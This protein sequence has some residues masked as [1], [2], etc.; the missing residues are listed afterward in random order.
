[1]GGDDDMAGGRQFDDQV[2]Q[3]VEVVQIDVGRRFVEHH[4]GSVAQHR[5]GQCQPGALAG[6]QSDA[7]VAERGLE[8][9]SAFE[10][11]PQSHDT[12]CVGARTIGRLWR[13]EA[14]RVDHRAGHQQRALGRQMGRRCGD[15]ARLGAADIRHQIEQGALATP[16]LPGDDGESGSS[17]AAQTQPIEDPWTVGIPERHRVDDHGRDGSNLGSG[18]IGGEDV[19]AD[20][21]EHRSSVGSA[22]KLL[23]DSADRPVRLGRQQ[24]RGKAD[25]EFDRSV[26]QAKP[27]GDGHHGDRDRGEQLECHRREERRAKRLG[28]CAAVPVS[29][30]GDRLDLVLGP[31][32]GDQRGQAPDDIEEVAG[33]QVHRSPT[34]IALGCG[35]LADEGGEEG[36]QRQRH[37]EDQHTPGVDEEHDHHGEDRYDGCGDEGGEIAGDI[38]LDAAHAGSGQ[39]ERHIVARTPIGRSR[40]PPAQQSQSHFAAHLVACS[41]I[42]D[43]ADGGKHPT[44]HQ[45]APDER[46]RSTEWFGGDE[47]RDHPGDGQRLPERH[48]ARCDA[49]AGES[50]RRS[51]GSRQRA[52]QRDVDWAHQV[53]E[54]LR[55]EV[56][57]V[58]AASATPVGM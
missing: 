45:Q 42:D 54:V 17:G 2:P 26:R 52:K 55:S 47:G 27:D 1:M 34:A 41:A 22:V 29:D 28:G 11:R 5:S 51:S 57:S 44:R 58:R 49:D 16:G 13:S 4:E 18:V 35:V 30:G 46:K 12:Q 56:D 40:Q 31:A 8:P 19:G 23:A 10:R 20:L 21:V 3:V 9:G 37:E 25:I 36:Q 14:E 24:D 32:V 7:V 53:A 33:Q 50:D 15:R 38:G 39:A 43:L 48:H 6:R